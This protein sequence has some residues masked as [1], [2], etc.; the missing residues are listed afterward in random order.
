MRDSTEH[1]GDK[2]LEQTDVATNLTKVEPGDLIPDLQKDWECDI[3]HVV[4]P[5]ASAL[6]HCIKDHLVCKISPCDQGIGWKTFASAS[7]YKQHMKEEHG[8]DDDDV[9]NDVPEDVDVLVSPPDDIDP[10]NHSD[11]TD[12]WIAKF[13]ALMR[14]DDPDVEDVKALQGWLQTKGFHITI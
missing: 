3:C 6:Q 9:P 14:S 12:E 8:V 10:R 5:F 2:S 1:R 4:I 7:E 13:S 11:D